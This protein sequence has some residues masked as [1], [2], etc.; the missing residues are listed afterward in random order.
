M[1]ALLGVAGI[2]SVSESTMVARDCALA[3]YERGRIHVQHVSA[4]ETVDAIERAK[5]AGTQVTCEATPHHLLLT[6][7][8]VRT[9]DTNMK[10]NPPLRA[11]SDRQAL[12]EGAALGRDRLHRHRP[13]ASRARGEGAAV[14]AGADGGHRARDR[15]R[16]APHRSRA[17]G[18][19][20][21]RAARGAHDRGRRA[22]R[23]RGADAWRPAHLQISASWTSR[24]TGTWATRATRAARRTAPSPA[25]GSLAA[26][27]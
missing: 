1:S 13:R 19:D 2:P 24:R 5:A 26:C 10:M 8:A 12:I 18:R 3:L 14:R 9:L 16:R 27:A 23:P 4:R 15:V 7:D 20:R 6:D 25:A 11:E 21:A 22:L 17:A